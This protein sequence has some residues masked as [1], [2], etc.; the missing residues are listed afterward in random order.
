MGNGEWGIVNGADVGVGGPGKEK[1]GCVPR[2]FRAEVMGLERAAD[3]V[4]KLSIRKALCANTRWQ[5]AFS[6][7]VTLRRG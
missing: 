6:S 1:I 7:A 3:L 4:G 2:K 5:N